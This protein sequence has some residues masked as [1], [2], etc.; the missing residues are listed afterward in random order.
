MIQT[1][2]QKNEEFWTNEIFR[3]EKSGLSR[4]QYCLSRNL[5]YWTFREKEKKFTT[6][7]TGELVKVSPEISTQLRTIE[8][9]IE[10]VFHEK[11]SIRVKNGFD[12]DLL[13]SVSTEM[14]AGI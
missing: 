3:W 6:L 5:S 13:R 11:F 14:E 7:L 2:K 10:I 1:S 9:S 4:K 8:S 12:A